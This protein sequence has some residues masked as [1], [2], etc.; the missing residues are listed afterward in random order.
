MKRHFSLIPCCSTEHRLMKCNVYVCVRWI[1][2]ISFKEPWAF[3]PHQIQLHCSLR[4]FCLKFTLKAK[5][6]SFGVSSHYCSQHLYSAWDILEIPPFP[7]KR[8]FSPFCDIPYYPVFGRTSTVTDAFH[9]Q[10]VDFLIINCD[11]QWLNFVTVKTTK[12][13]GVMCFLVLLI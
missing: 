4:C 3:F 11:Q 8:Y 13:F 12:S 7:F 10:P 5:R 2:R 9:Y 6:L 1:S